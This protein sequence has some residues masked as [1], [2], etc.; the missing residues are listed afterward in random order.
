[1]FKACT[2][3]VEFDS[4]NDFVQTQVSPEVAAFPLALSGKA[5]G[6]WGGGQ[7]T[8]TTTGHFNTAQL[9]VDGRAHRC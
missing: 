3:L 9:G 2:V 4:D 1:M 6:G 8:H 7:Q 5:G